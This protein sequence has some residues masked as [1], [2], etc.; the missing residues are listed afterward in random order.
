MSEQEIQNKILDYLNRQPDVFAWRNNSVGVYTNG[1]YRKKGGFNINGVSDIL[2][3]YSNG[4]FLAIEVKSD[5][6]KKPKP[7]EEQEA[8]LNKINR[9]NGYVLCTNNIEDVIELIKKI[10]S[11]NGLAE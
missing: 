8:F 3:V 1:V 9:M 2:G 6:I 7:S 10:R 4:K 5:T 11:E